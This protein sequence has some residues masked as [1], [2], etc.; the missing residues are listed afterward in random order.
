MEQGVSSGLSS[1]CLVEYMLQAIR[2]VERVRQSCSDSAPFHLMRLQANALIPSAFV[3]RTARP[4][5]EVIHH[6]Q[7]KAWKFLR[8]VVILGRCFQVCGRCEACKAGVV[9]DA[10]P[11]ISGRS[12]VKPQSPQNVAATP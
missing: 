11:P 10:T 8:P 9:T 2:T 3:E 4:A 7:D 1:D 12:G 5:G 6:G